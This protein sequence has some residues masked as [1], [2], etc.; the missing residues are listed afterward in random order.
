MT[1]SRFIDIAVFGL[2]ALIAGCTAETSNPATET[3]EGGTY[4]QRLDATAKEFA[5]FQLWKENLKETRWDQGGISLRVPKPFERVPTPASENIAQAHAASREIL[6]E[7]LPGVLGM[8]KAKLPGQKSG[9]S[10]TAY[11]F[12]MTNQH[13][14]SSHRDDA[15]AFH[16]TLIED[17]LAQ[18]PVPNNKLPIDSDWNTSSILGHGLPHTVGTF[19]ATIPKSKALANFTLYLMQYGQNDRRDE[20]KVALMFVVPVEAHLKGS[21]PDV[22]PKTLSAETLRIA[23]PPGEET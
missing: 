9:S 17:V 13:Y 18:L 7:P 19:Q 23:L 16:Q 11:L 1:P 12:L 21:R 14:P 3:G 8:W 22:D 4:Q 5:Y 2:A 20:I 10:Q 15:M 6:G